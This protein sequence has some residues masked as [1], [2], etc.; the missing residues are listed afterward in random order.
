MKLWMSLSKNRVEPHLQRPRTRNNIQHVG[1]LEYQ[2]LEPADVGV[3]N[4]HEIHS[5]ARSGTGVL[6]MASPLR[7][8]TVRCMFCSAAGRCTACRGKS[9]RLVARACETWLR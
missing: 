3:V 4:R 5:D 9:C 2:M 1:L 7:G 8:M 6:R